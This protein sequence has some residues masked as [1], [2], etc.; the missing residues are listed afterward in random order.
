VCDVLKDA[1]IEASTFELIGEEK[2][3]QSHQFLIDQ[4]IA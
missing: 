2:L 1:N 3:K 4:G